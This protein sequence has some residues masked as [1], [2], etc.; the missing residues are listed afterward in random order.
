MRVLV[1]EDHEVLAE[2]I[3]KG[4]RR[5]GMAVDVAL[6]GETALDRISAVDYDVVA[7]D[8]DLPGIHG[9]DVCR[10]LV[11]AR[12][13]TRILMLTASDTVRDRVHGLG[14]GADDYL[15]KPF[16]FAE[17]V[18]RVRAL[19]RRS[20]PA[21]PPILERSGV[22]L[23][24]NRRVAL[25]DGRRLI[26]SP[27]E[28]AVLVSNPLGIDCGPICASQFTPTEPD[29]GDMAPAGTKPTANSTPVSVSLTANP[30]SGDSLAAWSGCDEVSGDVC[31]VTD[32]N[33][34]SVQATFVVGPPPVIVTASSP[35]VAYGAA[36]PA[37]TPSY[38]NLVSNRQP[39]TAPTC[40][41]A[42]TQG[43]DA[44]IYPTSCSGAGDSTY[45]FSYTPG[46]VTITPLS[47]TTSLT[48]SST[49]DTSTYG[50]SVT[51]TAKVSASYG[52]PTG[53]L[54][55]KDGSTSLQSGSLSGGQATFTTTSLIAGTHSIKAVY[56]PAT[57]TKGGTNYTTSSSTTL[58]QTV[59]R[60]PVTV[61]AASPTV[62]YGQTG[63]GVTYWTSS[64]PVCQTGP[65][66]PYCKPRPVNAIVTC[67]YSGFQNGA[68]SPAIAATGLA[69]AS[70]GS[71]VGGYPTTCWGASDPNYVFSYAGGM[72]TIGPAS[73][74]VTPARTSFA[75]G[76]L[77]GKL[78]CTPTSSKAIRRRPSA[79]NLRVEQM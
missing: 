12:A 27:K 72:L 71:G 1:I 31:T 49:N 44:G 15:P 8:R 56:T 35:T 33:A 79:G 30:V 11:T 75:F 13:P 47:S 36:V 63:L 45:Y 24:P 61:T 66:N 68:T 74:T 73:L 38:A 65:P 26:L 18:A 2:A 57:N 78:H 29:T 42:A 77:L 32:S 6:D 28:F 54:T 43:S 22:M 17:L 4:L 62:R 23:D 10:E 46:S 67:G 76:Q 51:F 40:G 16:D 60:A 9:D 53:T 20:V 39:Q 50:Q 70:P 25:R 34:R 41:T 21:L 3:A 48:S 7:L 69:T 14:L 52:T 59:E 37:I 58:Q 5:E 19:G 64:S 55:F